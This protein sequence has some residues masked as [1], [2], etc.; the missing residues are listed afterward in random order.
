MKAVGI[1]RKVDD[2]GRIVIPKELRGIMEIEPGTSLELFTDDNGCVILRKYDFKQTCSCCGKI[3]ES[4]D[5]DIQVCKP[6]LIE[7]YKSMKEA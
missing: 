2:L 5:P 4:V 6:C 7:T 3:A 1:V